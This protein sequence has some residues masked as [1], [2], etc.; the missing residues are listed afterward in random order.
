MARGI[1]AQHSLCTGQL[2]ELQDNCAFQINPRAAREGQ[3]SKAPSLPYPQV[4]ISLIFIST[5]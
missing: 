3:E 4:D 2:Q 5:R 1:P